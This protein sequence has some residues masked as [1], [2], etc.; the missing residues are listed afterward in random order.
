LTIPSASTTLLVIRLKAFG[1][2]V[3][4]DTSDIRLI[5]THTKCYSRY[6]DSHFISNKGSVYK[7]KVLLYR[8]INKTERLQSRIKNKNMVMQRDILTCVTTACL[9]YPF[10]HGK[11]TS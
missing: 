3:M 9:S 7:C 4:D 8:V 11:C 5:Y 1:A 2:T 10:D 6:H